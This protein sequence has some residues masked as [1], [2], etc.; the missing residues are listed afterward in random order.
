MKNNCTGQVGKFAGAYHEIFIAMGFEDV[1][2]P[3]TL[4][5][6]DIPIDA[7]VAS[8]VDDRGFTAVTDDVR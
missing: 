4:P 8:R 1:R 2:D 7:A 6:G 3:H 5:V